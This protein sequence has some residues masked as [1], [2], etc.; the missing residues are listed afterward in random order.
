MKNSSLV[1]KVRATRNEASCQINLKR[2]PSI[3][4]WIISFAKQRIVFNGNIL[5]SIPRNAF[6]PPKYSGSIIR[7]D[8][9]IVTD[10]HN[11]QGGKVSHPDNISG[12]FFNQFFGYGIDFIGAPICKNKNRSCSQLS[13]NTGC[14]R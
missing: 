14:D 8:L 7:Y 4:Q 2:K 5:D 6:A 10:N 12:D 1:R 13:V 11:F 9:E 3:I